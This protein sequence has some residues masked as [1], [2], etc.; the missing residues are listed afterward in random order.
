MKE[1]GGGGGGGGN[2][3]KIVQ[4]ENLEKRMLHCKGSRKKDSKVGSE[5]VAPP[6]VVKKIIFLSRRSFLP[7]TLLYICNGK[8][9]TRRFYKLP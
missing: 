9:L 5:N 3:E 2:R 4:K 7:P 1:A 8:S 6:L